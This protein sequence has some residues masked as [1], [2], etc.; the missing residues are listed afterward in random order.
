MITITVSGADYSH[1]ARSE[2]VAGLGAARSRVMSALPPGDGQDGD[3]PLS[4]RPGYIADDTA[5]LQSTVQAWATR[6]NADG[7]AIQACTARC[8]ASWAG[9]PAP[10][11][12]PAEP[13]S[14]EAAKALLVAYASDKRW[15]VEVGG[16]LLGGMRVPTDDRAKLLLL[17]A[18][19]SM[20]DGSSAPLVIGGVN[21]GLRT[22]ADFQAINAAVVA[23]VQATFPKMATALAGIAAETITTTTQIDEVFA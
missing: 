6:E 3:T 17:G 18:S 21:Y 14:P 13:V 5:W 16:F 7:A 4:E 8:L 11:A 9:Q 1:D 20:A 23:H 19:S 2:E 15:R 22:K 10:E 12:P